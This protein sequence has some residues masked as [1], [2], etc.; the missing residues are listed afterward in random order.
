[1]ELFFCVRDSSWLP[2]LQS[3]VLVLR[4]AGVQRE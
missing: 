2:C 3:R 1:M 4:Q